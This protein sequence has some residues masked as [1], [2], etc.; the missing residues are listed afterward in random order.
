[1][2]TVYSLCLTYFK[3][4]INLNLYFVIKYI[5]SFE[6]QTAGFRCDLAPYGYPSTVL[7]QIQFWKLVLQDGT[8]GHT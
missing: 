2:C 8:T 4:Y 5:L 7:V 1:M 6:Y 3:N